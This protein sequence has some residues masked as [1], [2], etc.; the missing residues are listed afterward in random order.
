MLGDHHLFRKCWPYEASAGVPLTI[1]GPGVR[2][3]VRHPHPVC[4]EDI[5]PTLLDMVGIDIPASVDGQSLA[6]ILR[7]ESNATVRT[8]LHGEHAV[9]YAPDHANH[10]LVDRHWKYIW[11]SHDGREQLFNLDND[12]RECINLADD[13]MHAAT[14]QQWRMRLLEQLRDRPE[15][16]VNGGDLIPARPH[17]ALV[18]VAR[19][20]SHAGP[21]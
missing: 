10:Y 4:L 7:G 2:S 14:L 21:G 17:D 9:C 11:F 3:G 20:R 5:M 8:W 12:P 18:A 16:F 13:P 19:S 15:G 6:P 1:M